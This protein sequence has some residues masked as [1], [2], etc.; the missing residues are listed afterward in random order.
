MSLGR[1]KTGELVRRARNGHFDTHAKANPNLPILL[2]KALGEIS[3][4]EAHI[5][6]HVDM[7]RIV[8]VN[9]CILT[10]PEDEVVYAQRPKREGKTRFVKNRKPEP[11]THISVV[12][13]RTHDGEYELISA[14]LGTLAP[15]EPWDKSGNKKVS[16]PYWLTHALVWDSEEVVPG[17]ETNVRPW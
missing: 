6:T 16:I 1:L 4:N 11:T 3:G 13:R 2:A 15:H 12:L 9:N 10:R 5:A 7:G 14:W 17:T 8:G